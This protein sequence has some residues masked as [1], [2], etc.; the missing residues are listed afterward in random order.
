MERTQITFFFNTTYLPITICDEYLFLVCF[1]FVQK[2]QSLNFA[3]FQTFFELK[4]CLRSGVLYCTDLWFRQTFCKV[5]LN[6]YCT[7]FLHFVK[8]D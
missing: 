8:S 2:W 5:G 7:S 1:F 3:H 6:E 4:K